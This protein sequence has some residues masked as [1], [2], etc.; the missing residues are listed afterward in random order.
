MDGR[1]CWSVTGWT[2]AKAND[3]NDDARFAAIFQDNPGKPI[4]E[5]LHSK[6]G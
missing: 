1:S 6:F 2:K 5:C 3:N 4:P